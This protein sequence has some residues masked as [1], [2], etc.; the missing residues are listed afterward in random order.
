VHSALFVVIPESGDPW[1]NFLRQV[2]E[3]VDQKA[4]VRLAENVW[5]VDVH[6]SPAALGFLV[7]YAE[8]RRFSY[9]ILPFERE[10]QWLPAGFDP[11]TTQ[12]RSE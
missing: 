4:V 10:P 9:G 5:L 1:N 12:A 7:A 3:D 8:K 2:S 6:A 11:K